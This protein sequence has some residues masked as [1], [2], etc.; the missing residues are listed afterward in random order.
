ML[1]PNNVEKDWLNIK[2]SIMLLDIEIEPNLKICLHF[3]KHS[4]FFLMLFFNSYACFYFT[5]K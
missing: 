2:T 1:L 5:L 4:L 3:S